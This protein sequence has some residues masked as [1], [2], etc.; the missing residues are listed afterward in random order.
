MEI[1][2]DGKVLIKTEPHVQSDAEVSD[3]DETNLEGMEPQLSMQFLDPLKRLQFL[4]EAGLTG[5]SGLDGPDDKPF[6]CD[7]CDKCFKRKSHLTRHRILHSGEKPFPCDL[8]G[9][10]FTRSENRAR[11]VVQMHQEG[12]KFRCEVCNKAFNKLHVMMHHM[13]THS[14][15]RPYGCS[16]CGNRYFRADKLAAHQLLHIARLEGD[17]DSMRRYE[18]PEKSCGRKFTR[19][20]HMKRHQ[21]SHTGIKLHACSKG[22]EKR[23]SRRDNLM[24]HESTCG[25]NKSRKS[26]FHVEMLSGMDNGGD[27]LQIKIVSAMSEKRFHESEASTI[28]SIKMENT[29]DIV[30]STPAEAATSQGFPLGFS[31]GFISD[32]SRESNQG[33]PGQEVQPSGA[34]PSSRDGAVE[35]FLVQN[36]KRAELDALTQA[37]EADRLRSMATEQSL[38]LVDKFKQSLQNVITDK[39]LEQNQASNENGA[40]PATTLTEEQYLKCGLC[41]KQFRHKHHLLR[42]QWVH[43]GIKP[44]VC[45]YCNRAFTRKEHLNRHLRV[46]QKKD[47]VN[48]RS[49]FDESFGP[50][51]V[52][53]RSQGGLSEGSMGRADGEYFH[54]H[55]D[56][57]REEN[58]DDFDRSLE[59]DEN[60]GNYVS[61]MLE[62]S[63]SSNP[64]T[65]LEDKIDREDGG[66]EFDWSAG[67]NDYLH[68]QLAKT[69]TTPRDD[70]WN[71]TEPREFAC[72]KCDKVFNKQF[73]LSRHYTLHTG[74]KRFKCTICERGFTRLE[75]QKRH[76]ATHS[77]DRKYE[78]DRCDRKFSRSD[79]L[80]MHMKSS[81]TD[82][83][84]YRCPN[85]CGQ[86]FDT[87]REK[88]L[89]IHMRQ[90]TPY[91]SICELTFSNQNELEL[92]Q[93]T[94][95]PI[96]LDEAQ[97]QPAE[98]NIDIE[99]FQ[100]SQERI[101]LE[102]SER[103]DAKGAIE[104]QRGAVN[105]LNLN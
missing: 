28:D 71:R 84:P 41:D 51:D 90:C 24:K 5:L 60:S 81:H 49:S 66:E 43:L 39:L 55:Q 32:P 80:L 50:N 37:E 105:P 77:N 3:F 40:A 59:Y 53:T 78:C 64:V 54:G 87:F 86:R 82:I 83:K 35:I 29:T 18:C 95:D 75:H 44:F 31:Q 89:H 25:S 11:H 79:H 14:E 2:F 26:G 97:K 92:H 94:H 98:E 99:E 62:I 103:T 23:F 101:K 65:R 8:C 22:C 9:E 6:K 63:M 36:P 56:I 20:D 93:Q 1:E 67:S 27:P 72:D 4:R 76:L 46:H 13:K 7:Q 85:A 30:Q 88:S 12:S 69:M 10:R 70:K 42:H 45:T 102:N 61:S 21:A 57:K 17:K 100:Q 91:C 96:K 38:Q 47:G 48:N 74:E 16:I 58:G 33:H 15:E 52:E 34:L 104:D 73:L 68:S 19:K